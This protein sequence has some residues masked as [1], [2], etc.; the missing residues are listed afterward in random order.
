MK[1]LHRKI[2]A[3]LLAGMVVVGGVAVSGVSSFAYSNSVFR[4]SVKQNQLEMKE[5]RFK[6]YCNRAGYEILEASFEESKINEL[7]AKKELSGES[8]YKRR[9]SIRNIP[10]LISNLN[11]LRRVAD[12]F[13]KVPFDGVYYL[14][15]LK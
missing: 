6:F 15:R 4:N 5:Q 14:I 13:A 3:M 8:V 11:S 1:N 12:K 10:Q 2:S 9:M 7:I